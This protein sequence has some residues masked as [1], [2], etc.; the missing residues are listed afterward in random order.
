MLECGADVNVQTLG[1]ETP[2]MVAIRN[3]ARNTVRLLLERGASVVLKDTAGRTALDCAEEMSNDR[4]R[5]EMVR[6]LKEAATA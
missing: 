2:L 3:G 6:L 4:T 1:G 5:T